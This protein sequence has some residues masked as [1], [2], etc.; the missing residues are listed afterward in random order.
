MNKFA[1]STLTLCGLFC[2]AAVATAEHSP[3]HKRHELMEAVGDAAKPL[4]GMLRGKMTFDA[5]VVMQS[6]TTWRESAEAFGD[7]FPAGSETGEGTEAAPEIWSDRAG[8]DASLAKFLEDTNTAIAASP[9]TLDAARP[10]IGAAFKNCKG[11]HDKYR[12]EDE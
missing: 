6:L 4:G 7:L 8:F 12:I 11:C 1:R 10:L 5:D 3:Q 2:V 9:Q